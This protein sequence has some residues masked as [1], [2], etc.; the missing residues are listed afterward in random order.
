MARARGAVLVRDRTALEQLHRAEELK[1]QAAKAEGEVL[2]LLGPLK[3]R[4]R[5]L[6]LERDRLLYDAIAARQNFF[7]AA[8]KP[9]RSWR[10]AAGCAARPAAARSTSAGTT[11]ARTTRPGRASSCPNS[12]PSCPA[13]PAAAPGTCSSG[14]T[15]ASRTA[16]PPLS[17]RVPKP[18]DEGSLLDDRR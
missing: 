16:A 11:P 10:S 2:H 3:D 18:R 14:W 15:S 8:K 4:L 5:E 1:E 12:T 7:T 13:S 9:T 6:V 17:S